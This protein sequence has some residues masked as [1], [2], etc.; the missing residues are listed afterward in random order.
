MLEEFKGQASFLIVL[1]RKLTDAFGKVDSLF[2]VKVTPGGKMPAFI[3]M[4]WPG[5]IPDLVAHIEEK[6]GD[7][8]DRIVSVS[9]ILGWPDEEAVVYVKP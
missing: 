4:D 2:E 9:N 7:K 6:Y 8:P 3:I 1:E 5:A